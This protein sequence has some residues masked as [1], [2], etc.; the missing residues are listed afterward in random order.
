MIFTSKSLLQG[1]LSSLS[2]YNGARQMAKV[3]FEP[4]YLDA[5]K[6]AHPIYDCVNVCTKSYDFTVIERY[7]RFVHKTAN[8]MGLNVTETWA[9]PPRVYQI[10][11]FKPRS[12]LKDQAY[13]LFLYE[14]NVQISEFPCYL[15]PVFAEFIR[16][17]LPEGAQLSIHNHEKEHE[18]MRYIPDTQLNELK[19]Q[20]G[21]IVEPPKS[22]TGKKK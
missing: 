17:S 14:R 10:D 2:R 12:T 18:E 11:T 16:A 6:P 3:S 5:L 1:C 22:N 13:K 19:T 7:S 4:D 15:M 8:K 21:D 20:L 9:T